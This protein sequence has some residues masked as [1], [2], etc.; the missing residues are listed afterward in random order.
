[1]ALPAALP[2][3][4]PFQAPLVH[5]VSAHQTAQTGAMPAPSLPYDHLHQIANYMYEHQASPQPSPARW[6]PNKTDSLLLERVFLLER[7]PGR[8]LRQQL[9]AH[10]NVTTRQVQVWF[11]NKRQRTRTKCRRAGGGK[12][13]VE[14]EA[15][16]AE[17]LAA[18][19]PPVGT[20]AAESA[21]AAAKTTTNG[22]DSAPSAAPREEGAESDV[23]RATSSPAEGKADPVLAPAPAPKVGSKRPAPTAESILATARAS[24]LVPQSTMPAPM[25]GRAPPVV[26][27]T[28]VSYT[29]PSSATASHVMP[30]IAPGASMIGLTPQGMLPAPHPMLSAYLPPTH[31]Q[32]PPAVATVAAGG[33]PTAAHVLSHGAAAPVVTHTMGINGV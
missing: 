27:A 19:T 29:A 32:L 21:P 14:T 1:M 2:H 30:A 5:T 9:A 10:L 33:V 25:M 18:G 28:V 24:S 4:V 7:C 13:E 17:A 15:E 11:Q 31:P 22:K 20:A 8:D 23:A 16:L 3:Q 26:A 6:T 12:S